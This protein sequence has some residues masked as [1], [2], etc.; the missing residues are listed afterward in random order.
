MVTKTEP[1]SHILYS[2]TTFWDDILRLNLLLQRGTKMHLYQKM[3][4]VKCLS[5]SGSNSKKTQNHGFWYTLKRVLKLM[6]LEICLHILYKLL[7]RNS[8]KTCNFIPEVWD[9]SFFFLA[10]D[11]EII[12]Y[13]SPYRKMFHVTTRD[14]S[15]GR[16]MELYSCDPMQ[17]CHHPASKSQQ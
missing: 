15:K 3:D 13:N 5:W 9:F 16:C 8:C 1:G 14:N 2:Q 4:C 11:S 7:K 6:A 17:F 10:C 12:F